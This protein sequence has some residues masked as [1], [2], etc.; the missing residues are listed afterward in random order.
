MKFQICVKQ[1][2]GIHIH[3]MY[4]PIVCELTGCGI[5]KRNTIKIN[6]IRFIME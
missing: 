3:V 6:R 1:I 2:M 4:I 5:Q